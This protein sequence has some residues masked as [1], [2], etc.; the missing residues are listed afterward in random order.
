MSMANGP[1]AESRPR[2]IAFLVKL[3]GIAD[4]FQKFAP[5]AASAAEAGSRI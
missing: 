5:V 3:E 2:T 4:V 1:T